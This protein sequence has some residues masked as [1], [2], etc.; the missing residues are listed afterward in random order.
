MWLV[1]VS[2]L[3][4]KSFK[5][6][7][8]FCSE[9]LVTDTN[10]FLSKYLLID[11]SIKNRGIAFPPMLKQL[12]DSQNDIALAQSIRS[13]HDKIVKYDANY[14]LVPEI[15]AAYPDQVIIGQTQ[16]PEDITAYLC[17]VQLVNKLH[18]Y[19][20]FFFRPQEER[21]VGDF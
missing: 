9:S 20:R 2:T 12:V 19:I 15:S 6:A 1:E 10:V 8:I 7:F 13:I 18:L 11:A 17:E 5:D 16:Y 14:G 21:P 3:V 4:W